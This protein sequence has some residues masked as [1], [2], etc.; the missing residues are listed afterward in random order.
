MVDCS[1]EAAIL[2]ISGRGG[3]LLMFGLLAAKITPSK[4][5]QLTCTHLREFNVGSITRN[6]P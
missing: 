5:S 3:D 1:R 4:G 6:C 2:M